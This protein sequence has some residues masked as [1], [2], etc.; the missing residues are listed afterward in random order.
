MCR[1]FEY[2]LFC[3]FY[4]PDLTSFQSEFYNAVMPRMKG[5][6]IPDVFATRDEGVH[7]QMRRPVAHLYSIANLCVFE[8]LIS[9]TL[10]YFFTR[11]DDLFTDKSGVSVDLYR[12]MQ[13]LTF[14]VIGEVTFSRRLGFLEKGSDIE[15]VIENNWAFFEAA[16][17]VRLSSNS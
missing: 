17:P 5:G 15:G 2:C 10:A 8:P 1:P 14:D 6:T 11:L 12:W 7:R 3:V 16:A 13:F 4:E 9:S